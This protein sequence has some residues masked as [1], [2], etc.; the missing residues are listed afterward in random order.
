LKQRIEYAMTLL[1]KQPALDISEI[2]MACGFADQSHFTRL[3]SR[4]VGTTP[5]VWRRQRR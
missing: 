3:F 5:A 2:A 4:F 1:E